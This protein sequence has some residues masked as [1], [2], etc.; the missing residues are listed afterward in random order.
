[1]SGVVRSGKLEFYFPSS[2]SFKFQ[3]ALIKAKVG[4]GLREIA[5]SAASF[6]KLLGSPGI[7]IAVQI[8]NRNVR[9][10]T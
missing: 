8:N 3:A 4:K 7:S 1:M 5:Y 6:D 9:A 2:T 10:L